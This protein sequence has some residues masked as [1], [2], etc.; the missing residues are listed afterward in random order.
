MKIYR[1]VYSAKYR[2]EGARYHGRHCIVRQFPK[3]GTRPFNCLVQLKGGELAVI[4]YGN[5]KF[6]AVMRY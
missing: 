6:E 1:I 5:L 4:P 2:Q 3:K